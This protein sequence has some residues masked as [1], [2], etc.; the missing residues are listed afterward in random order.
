MLD[1]LDDPR[2][3]SN[4]LLKHILAGREHFKSFRS[5]SLTMDKAQ[6]NGLGLAAGGIVAPDNVAALSVI[7]VFGNSNPT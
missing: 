6:V 2:R 1:V 3:L 4:E 5:L 7:Q